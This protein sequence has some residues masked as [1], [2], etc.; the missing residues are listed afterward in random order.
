M[1]SDRILAICSIPALFLHLSLGRPTPPKTT[2]IDSLHD[3]ITCSGRQST[4]TQS[5]NRSIYR[6][7]HRVDRDPIFDGAEAEKDNNGDGDGD[8]KGMVDIVEGEIWYHWDQATLGRVESESAGRE[9][10]GGRAGQ[11]GT[12]LTHRRNKPPPS[13]PH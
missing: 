1:C 13:S 12:G 10:G 3:A 8:E 5:L 2:R 4:N 11:A 9:E 6:T 7:P